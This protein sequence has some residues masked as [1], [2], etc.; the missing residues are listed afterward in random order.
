MFFNN[1]N[2]TILREI[3]PTGA[4]V[5]RYVQSEEKDHFARKLNGQINSDLSANSVYLKH[6]N[7]RVNS[8][9]EALNYGPM[10]CNFLQDKGY[11]NILFVGHFNAGQLSWI[12]DASADRVVDLLPP[13]RYHL[14]QMVDPNIMLQFVPMVHAMYTYK[15]SASVVRPPESRHRAVMHSLYSKNGLKDKM[16]GSNKQ[17]RHGMIDWTLDMPA[18]A[19]KFDAVVFLGV[20]K[21]TDSFE[22]ETVRATFSP[23]C[24]P[25]FAMVDLYYNQGDS[26]KWVNGTKKDN[27]EGLAKVFANRAQWD[28]EVQTNG[29]RPE[30]LSIMDRIINVF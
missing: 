10:Y 21:H 18:D 17:Y 24:T 4:P 8:V 7:S 22:I 27:T 12:L 29:G 9:E 28:D 14:G 19:A 23:Y 1:L 25:G 5:Y 16:L 3:G 20:P 2:E 11:K 26:T 15:T 30:E 6:A 13:E